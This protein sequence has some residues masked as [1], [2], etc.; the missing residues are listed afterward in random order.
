M[1]HLV[2][3]LCCLAW[4]GCGI[5]LTC[6]VILGRSMS[7]SSGLWADCIS[8]SVVA[9][10][11]TLQHIWSHGAGSASR[12]I[13]RSDTALHLFCLISTFSLQSQFC[14]YI[15]SVGTLVQCPHGNFNF[16]LFTLL[17][18]CCSKRWF[19]QLPSN[20]DSLSTTL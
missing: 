16:Y 14:L 5:T 9:Q 12:S 11:T 18:W 19:W 3:G 7:G 1:V 17:G 15:Y 13:W 10:I 4:P 8:C 6:I 2:G 20:S